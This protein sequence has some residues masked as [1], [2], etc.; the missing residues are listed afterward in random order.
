MPSADSTEAARPPSPAGPPSASRHG[1]L[2]L[3]SAI[4]ATVAALIAAAYGVAKDI[5]V[6]RALAWNTVLAAQAA[7]LCVNVHRLHGRAAAAE[8]NRE[9]DPPADTVKSRFLRWE[10]GG[11]EAAEA[12]VAIGSWDLE[13][14]QKLHFMFLAVV[15]TSA[16]LLLATRALWIS[17]TQAAVAL[18][19]GTATAL[20]LVCL[21]GSCLWLILTRTYNG[22]S[23]EELPETGRLA[24]AFRELQWASIL[25]VGGLLSSCFWPALMIWAGRAVLGWVLVVASEQLIRLLA[26]RLRSP[27]EGLGPAPPPRIFLRESVFLHGSPIHSVFETIELT[28]GVSFRASWA[29]QFVRR[30]VV[31]AIL[32]VTLLLWGLSSLAVVQIDQLGIRESFGR[33]QSAPLPPGLHWKLP[34]PCGRVLHYP[35]KRVVVKPIGF[36]ANPGRQPSFLWS[37]K[38]ANEEFGLVLGDGAELVASDC[39]VYYKIHEDRQRFLDY[40]YQSQNPEDLLE[41]YAYRTLME[42]TRSLTLREVLTGNRARFADRL[43]QTLRDYAESNRLGIEVVE[44]ALMGLHPPVEAA[45]DYLDVISARIDAERVQVDALGQKS[46]QIA[47]VR[48]ESASAIASAKVEAARRT[49]TALSESSEFLAIGQAYAVAPEAFQLRLWFEALEEILKQK[50]FVLVDESVKTSPGGILLDHRG[51]ARLGSD[52]VPLLRDAGFSNSSSVQ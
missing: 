11:G 5:F 27:C 4:L 32:L 1:N 22:I 52:P 8:Q 39:V 34:W 28:L 50:R 31:P 41:A 23:K 26:A 46:V 44:V 29:I 18:P 6:L 48:Q 9:I 20:A 45:A 33:I 30:S 7:W 3:A 37:K 21:A 35:G 38:H 40:V 17:R 42:H 2:V 47:N 25:T 51:Q 19:A 15:P 14:A 12:E 49:G 36:I 16:I 24:L 10:G 43:E 13:H